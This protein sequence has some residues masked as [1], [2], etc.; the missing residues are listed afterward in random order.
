MPV[1]VLDER[2]QKT[3]EVDNDSLAN[4]DRKSVV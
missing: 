2:A 1:Q 4:A 3:P